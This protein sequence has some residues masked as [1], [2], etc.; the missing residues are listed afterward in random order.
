M[1]KILREAEGEV[2]EVIDMCD[3]AV[4]LSRKIGGKLIPSEREGHIIMER[5][6]PLGIVGVITAFNFPVAVF[7]WNFAL[8]FLCGNCTLWKGAS[9]VSMTTMITANIINNVLIENNVPE[10]ALASIVGAGRVIGNAICEDPRI[11]LISFT[12]STPVGR[13]V[14]KKVHE[15][16][17][18]TILELGGNNA[19]IVCDDAD[20]QLAVE[21]AFFGAIGTCGQRCTSTRRLIVHKSL[22]E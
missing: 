16:F 5:W 13:D 10:G 17:G 9:S 14:S 6:L 2:Q 3:F 12:G 15:R 7:G 20:L 18:R 11:T 4:G 19:I 21:S 1:G 22:Y 8:S